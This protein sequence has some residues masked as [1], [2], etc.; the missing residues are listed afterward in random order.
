MS[1][2]RLAA[3]ACKEKGIECFALLILQRKHQSVLVAGVV[4]AKKRDFVGVSLG[5]SVEGGAA[6]AAASW[7]LFG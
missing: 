4:G 5:K 1:R 2:S 3:C 7:G 6:A